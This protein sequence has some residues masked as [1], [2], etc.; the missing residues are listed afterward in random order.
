[1]TLSGDGRGWVITAHHHDPVVLP[2]QTPPAALA[3][4]I[5]QDLERSD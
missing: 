4:A 1:V 3:A 2:R 5:V